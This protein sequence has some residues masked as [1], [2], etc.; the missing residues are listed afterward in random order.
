M[1]HLILLR[2]VDH[3]YSVGPCGRPDCEASADRCPC[4]PPD[5]RDR[6]ARIGEIYRAVR[7]RF[8]DEVEI[9]VI[10]PRNVFAYAWLLVRDAL[11]FRVPAGTTLRAL[12]ANSVSSAVF[13]GQLLF[14]G[15]PPPPS[16]V[17]DLI[18]GR[19]VVFRV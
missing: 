9:T 7:E 11:R 8:G 13:D 12:A 17:V 1:H 2:E 4:V 10:D 6:V 14:Q 15:T 19:L 18:L 5:R 16:R 3:R